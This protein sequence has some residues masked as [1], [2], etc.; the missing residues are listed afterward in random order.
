MTLRDALITVTEAARLM[1]ENRP[2]KKALWVVDQKIERLRM[3]EE[4]RREAKLQ[5][6]HI[7]NEAKQFRI[8]LAQTALTHPAFINVREVRRVRA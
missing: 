4:R 6:E 1:P 7:A 5:R 3:K 2:L 8:Q